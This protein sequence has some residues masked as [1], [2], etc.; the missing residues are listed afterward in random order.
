MA[1]PAQTKTW[2]SPTILS[3]EDLH[4]LGA[5]AEALLIQKG[6]IP[7]EEWVANSRIG[8][9][10]ATPSKIM[11]LAHDHMASDIAINIEIGARK[12]CVSFKSHLDILSAAPLS[13]RLHSKPLRIP[14][15]LNGERTFVEPDALFSIG[16][17]VFALE[18]DKGTESIKSVIVRKILAYREI[19]AAG[20]IDDYLGI[21]NIRVL[22][23]TTS[24]KRM[25]YV[26]DE[27]AKIARNGKSTMFGFRVDDAFGD[28]LRSPMPTGRLFAAPVAEG[29]PPRHDPRRSDGK[30]ER[31]RVSGLPFS[32]SILD[33][34]LQRRHR[35]TAAAASRRRSNDCR[36]ASC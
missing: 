23:A 27:L 13:T 30:I 26:M 33:P 5:E 15:T 31:P 16:G 10:S 3:V 28:F 8:G 7:A 35:H 22:F 9:K 4:G 29:R 12:A 36:S 11:R 6:V 24:L 19:V 1:P 21:D 18:A 2:S 34:Y 25:Q 17:R 14:V 20:I 32:R